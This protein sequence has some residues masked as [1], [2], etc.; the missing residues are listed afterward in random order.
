MTDLTLI[1][2]TKLLT[3]CEYAL[4]RL[5]EALKITPKPTNN[6]L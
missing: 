1:E 2:L 4:T 5:E 6:E 3:K